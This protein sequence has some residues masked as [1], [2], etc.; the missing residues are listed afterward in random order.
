MHA[1]STAAAGTTSLLTPETPRAD[2]STSAMD[3]MAS[4][5]A[6]LAEKML[7]QQAAAQLRR[8]RYRESVLSDT[9]TDDS[10]SSSE[11]GHALRRLPVPHEPLMSAHAAR[12][13]TLKDG[14]ISSADSNGK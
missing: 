5:S 1:L 13:R 10:H 7:Q 11:S 3:T 6:V 4:P 14:S 2:E 9:G 12:V 8:D